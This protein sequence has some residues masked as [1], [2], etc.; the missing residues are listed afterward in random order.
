MPYRFL[1][2]F[3]AIQFAVFDPLYILLEFNFA[4]LSQKFSNRMG[5]Y[6][7]FLKMKWI[8]NISLSHNQPIRDQIFSET[9]LKR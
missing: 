5:L 3:E 9:Q 1:I 8:K 2:H 4:P 7:I 6:F